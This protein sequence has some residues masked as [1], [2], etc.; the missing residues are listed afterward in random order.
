MNIYTVGEIRSTGKFSN[1]PG[2]DTGIMAKMDNAIELLMVF[3]ESSI[4]RKKWAVET[5]VNIMM[6]ISII[7]LAVTMVV[8]VLMTVLLFLHLHAFDQVTLQFSKWVSSPLVGFIILIMALKF[9]G[10][11][12]GLTLT[13]LTIKKTTLKE[14]MLRFKESLSKRL[15]LPIFLR[16]KVQAHIN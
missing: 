5:F 4:R 2:L 13:I 8:L 3:I 10:I 7:K 9:A 15:R 1:L 12:I 11:S 16:N 14:V 6:K